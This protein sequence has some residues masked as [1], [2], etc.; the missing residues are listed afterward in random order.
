MLELDSRLHGNDKLVTLNLIQGLWI[1]D[2][3][4]NDRIYPPLKLRFTK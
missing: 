3:V 4:R 1:T 2:H